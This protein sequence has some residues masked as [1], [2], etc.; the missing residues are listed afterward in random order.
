MTDMIKGKFCPLS[1]LTITGTARG[2]DKEPKTSH[3]LKA[4]PALLTARGDLYMPYMTVLL[5]SA[6]KR[7]FNMPS[8][9]ARSD[10]TRKSMPGI[11]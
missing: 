10:Q 3:A 6:P 9:N 2:R 5:A 7:S 1:L 11:Y 8:E 4:P